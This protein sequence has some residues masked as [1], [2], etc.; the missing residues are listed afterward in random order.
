MSRATWKRTERDI[1]RIVVGGRH[2]DDIVCFRL[3][4][5]V[6]WFGPVAESEDRSCPVP[7]RSAR[8]RSGTRSTR[9]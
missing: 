9:R 8:T 1:A 4:D 5:F 6:Q 3:A 2:T 7:A